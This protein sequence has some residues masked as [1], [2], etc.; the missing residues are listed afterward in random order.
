M[1]GVH[2]QV[3]QVGNALGA[4][5]LTEIPVAGMLCFVDADW[6]L[7][8]G[9]FTISSVRVLW[10]KKAADHIAKPGGVDPPTAEQAFRALAEAFPA[11]V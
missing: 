2:K 9:D 7:I 11:Y 5:G 10:P 1:D 8:G 4:A 3:S 6:P